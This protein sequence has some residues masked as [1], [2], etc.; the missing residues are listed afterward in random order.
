MDLG[1]MVPMIFV[2]VF[3]WVTSILY[4]LFFDSFDDILPATLLEGVD[5]WFGLL[6]ASSVINDALR[7]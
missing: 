4:A 6:F 5:V 7:G 3:F 2:M 1:V